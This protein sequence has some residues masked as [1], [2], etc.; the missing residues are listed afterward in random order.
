MN[1]HTRIIWVDDIGRGREYRNRTKLWESIAPGELIYL[2][3]PDHPVGILRVDGLTGLN[4]YRLN[5]K[6]YESLR[7]S[8]Y[9]GPLGDVIRFSRVATGSPWV[10]VRRTVAQTER[11][12]A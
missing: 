7:G 1:E 6:Y 10:Q 11:L 5:H 12:S 2:Y 4:Y 8:A 9:N 3:I